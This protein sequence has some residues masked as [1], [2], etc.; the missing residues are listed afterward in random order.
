MLGLRRRGVSTDEHRR[1]EAALH[2][3]ARRQDGVIALE[4]AL[5]L[6]YSHTTV[7]RKVARKEWIRVAYRVYQLASHEVSPRATI[8][9]AML[10]V[11][12]EAVLVG[13]AAAWWWGLL[14]DRPAPI[15][16]AVA[17]ETRRRRR[18][19]VLVVRRT[20]PASDRT[21]R[22]G[23][24][25]TT[26]VATVLD[27]AATL[28]T[29]RGARIMDRALQRR[30]VTLEALRHAQLK[31]SGRRG[32]PVTAGLL[33]LAAGGAV[34]EAE[35]LAHSTMRLAGIRGWRANVPVEVPGFGRAVLDV[36][37]DEEKVIL[38]IDGWAYHRDLRAFLVDGPRQTALVADGWVVVRTHWY[39]LT[40]TPEVVVAS[41]RRVL[42]SRAGRS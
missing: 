2:A 24:R 28:G 27:A 21:T 42:A 33:A 25:V 18:P 36:V 20:V 11:G 23:L 16:I 7:R 34:S 40:A 5:A 22:R 31:R 6:G 4:Q 19:G 41:L 32:A 12:D 30:V 26:L 38:E 17:R 15:E 37:F 10:S 29:T 3:L 9:A 14:D 1:R 13:P 39:E 8:R 35:R